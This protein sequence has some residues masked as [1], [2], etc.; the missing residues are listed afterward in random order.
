MCGYRDNA[1]RLI[2]AVLK[3]SLFV[4]FDGKKN[5][6][7]PSRTKHTLSIIICVQQSQCHS[8]DLRTN[9][10][11]NK[12]EKISSLTSS[13]NFLRAGKRPGYNALLSLK[14]A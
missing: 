3:S 10:K 11:R 13:S 1:F 8:N 4:R 9:L 7:R 12:E 14:S 5:G 6:F 2:N